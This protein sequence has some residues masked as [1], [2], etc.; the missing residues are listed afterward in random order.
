MTPQSI[1][2]WA[3]RRRA[4][5]SRH[6]STL[7]VQ[8]H[9]EPE[10]K[11]RAGVAPIVN[12][13]PAIDPEPAA[14]RRAVA[15]DALK[16]FAI[17][18]VVYIHCRNLAGES[19]PVEILGE[20][21]RISVPLFIIIWA[22]F[23]ERA[24]LAG[25][26][27]WSMVSSRFTALVVPFLVWSLLYFLLTSDWST[28]TLR[29]AITRHW[30][31]SGWSGQYFF[32]ILFQLILVFPLVRRLPAG[33]RSLGLMFGLFAVAFAAVGLFSWPSWIAKLSYRPFLYWL[34]YVVL[35]VYLARSPDW[36]LPRGAAVLGVLLIVAEAGLLW[37]Q[38]G[39]DSGYAKP[40]VLIGSG[41]VAAAFLNR[42]PAPGRVS[43]ASRPAILLIGRNT[44]GI[45]LINPLVSVIAAPAI[46]RRF[47]WHGFANPAG[48][49]VLSLVIA[50]AVL[51]LCLAATV[52][53]K[54]L[55]LR[56]L[57]G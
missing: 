29:T 10:G 33:A 21:F 9:A 52:T 17:F 23:Q 47:D 32:I 28:L 11:P 31:G 51:A 57:V 26:S 7:R 34:P 56:Q 3:P 37:S 1:P 48:S 18:G 5:P 45:F 2:H 36:F 50:A 16:A 20:A 24:Y 14:S 38:A 12:S 54:R 46:A 40:G 25:G 49:L 42:E 19:P 43:G 22:Y 13:I 8:S 44:M 39:F 30:L 4:S 41:L 15:P 55:G 53:L 35:G 27:P 6:A